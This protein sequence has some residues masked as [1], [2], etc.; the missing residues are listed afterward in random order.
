MNELG[1]NNYIHIMFK[2][3]PVVPGL[4]QSSLFDEY[5]EIVLYGM[6]TFF[7]AKTY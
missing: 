4:S 6:T 7:S 1:L 5:N 2:K 3:I